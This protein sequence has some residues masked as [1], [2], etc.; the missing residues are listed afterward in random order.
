MHRLALVLVAFLFGGSALAQNVFTVPQVPVY[1]EAD[2]SALAQDQARREGREAALDILL[3]RIVAEE[4]WIYLPRLAEGE[5]APVLGE[6]AY[7]ASEE[8]D[9]DSAYSPNAFNRQEE[10]GALP[11]SEKQPIIIDSAQLSQLEEGFDVFNEKSSGTTYR[12]Q[13]TFRF[14][15]DAI[16]SLL[17]NARLPYSE[18]QARD[19]LVLPVLQ[20][21]TGVYL[22]EA[23]NPWARAWLE[24]PLT[25]ELTPMQLPVGDVVDIQAITAEE[26]RDLN[27][28]SLREFAKRYQAEQVYLALGQLGENN[29]EYR[30]FV[31]LIDATPPA[32]G[33]SWQA[34]AIGTTVSEAFFRGADDDFP[35][36]ARRAVEGTVQRHARQWKRQTLVDYSLQRSFE[37][38]AWYGDL[39]EWA[40]IRS[41]L[42]STPLVRNLD[43]GVFNRENAIIQLTVV[44]DDQQFDLAMEQ[45]GLDLWRD[46]SGR[47][48]LAEQERAAQ[49]QN[50]LDPLA[51]TIDE[52]SGRN[53]SLGLG[54]LFGRRDEETE[55]NGGGTNPNGAPS[56]PEGD[57]PELPDDLFGDDG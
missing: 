49:L 55:G 57:I 54:R 10:P 3:R 37:V 39:E 13:I 15:P 50:T 26:A 2:T 22:W 32:I 33:V 14:K 24:R 45:R 6:N 7:L 25:S 21:D 8:P 44:G 40:D 41:A 34:S 19:V 38:T 53:R 35:A 16:R 27:A 43:P 28:A 48:Y 17:Q 52:Q 18:E 42:E 29:G 23:K 20:T 31:K 36:L 51:P 9:Y 12:A 5:P 11:V 4:D 30:L 47:W 46:A 56:A 1:A